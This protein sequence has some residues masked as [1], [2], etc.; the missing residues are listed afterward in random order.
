MSQELGQTKEDEN[1]LRR[2][3]VSKRQSVPEDDYYV[4]AYR[5]FKNQEYLGHD[6]QSSL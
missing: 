4:L 6:E 3:C 5:I 2:G 1:A